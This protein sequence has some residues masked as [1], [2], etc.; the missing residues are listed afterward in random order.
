ML[1]LSLRVCALSF[2]FGNNRIVIAVAHTIVFVYHNPK[3]V[4]SRGESSG[5]DSECNANFVISHSL[6][7][8][9]PLTYLT[10]PLS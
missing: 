4:E 7:P 9:P 3:A 1:T 6:P 8:H 10:L 2:P 5:R